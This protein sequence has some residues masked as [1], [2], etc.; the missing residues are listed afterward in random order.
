MCT[1][2]VRLD[3]DGAW[4]LLVAFVRDEERSRATLPPDR[5]WPEQPSVIGGR[6]ERAGGTWLAVDLD[7]RRVAFVQNQIGPHVR[8][9]DAATSPSRGQLP[10]AALADEAFTPDSLDDLERYQPF[11]LIV[12]DRG[13]ARWWQWSG[14]Q[15]EQVELQPGIHLV[16]SRGLDLPGERERRASQVERFANAA[17]PDPDPAAASPA[18]WGEWIGLLDGRG[19]EPGDLGG[20][21]LHSV[22][23]RPGF[24][25]VGAT[26]VAL[27]ADGRVRY[28]ANAT[29]SIAPDAWSQVTVTSASMSS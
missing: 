1:A 8:F 18:A 23:E 26:L 16:A 7:A 12:A 25:T 17:A 13:R 9:P 10:L 6:D 3:P 4:P 20:I 5:W 24:G 29:T 19:V 2:I 22:P 15:L 21:V 11:H 28:D 27:G 14:T